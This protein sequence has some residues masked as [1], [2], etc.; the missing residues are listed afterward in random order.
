[1][2]DDRPLAE[3]LL[4]PVSTGKIGLHVSERRLSLVPEHELNFS[5]LHRLKSRCGLEP[6][7]KTRERGWRHRLEDV[8]LRH[9][10]LHD[11]S[12][13]LKQMN[14]AEEIARVKILFYFLELVQQL[15][16]P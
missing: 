8:H 15:L 13:P 14:R 12:D 9:E 6:V 11:C 1:M 10:R 2:I 16:K 5:E 4:K 3:Q 7:A